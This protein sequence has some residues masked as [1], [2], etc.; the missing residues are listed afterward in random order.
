MSAA[1]QTQIDELHKWLAREDTQERLRACIDRAVS[2]LN[3]AIDDEAAFRV[4]VGEAN[5]PILPREWLSAHRGR[6]GELIETEWRSEFPEIARRAAE[7]IVAS[8][9]SMAWAPVEPELTA[10][11]LRAWA[12]GWALRNLG[13]AVIV[14]EPQLANGAW[15]VPVSL[16]RRPEAAAELALDSEF[17]VVSDRS[18]V[19]QQLLGP[20]RD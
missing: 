9:A 11:A 15:R 17:R 8:A 2:K 1:S 7:G 18:L 20:A 3:H 14:G 4:P 10:I 19:R 13:D 12:S 16:R 6:L 5:R